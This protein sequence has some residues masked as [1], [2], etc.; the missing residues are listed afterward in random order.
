MILI[1]LSWVYIFLT[2]AVFGLA[3]SKVLRIQQ[4]DV[5][6]TPI[7]GLFSVTIFAT[8]WAFFSPIN[9][10]FHCVLCIVSVVFWYRN[11]LGFQT[12][13]QNALYQFRL[14]SSPIKI[15][16]TFSSLLILTQSATSPFIIDNESYYIQTIKW[17]NEYGFIKGLANLHLFLGQ[18]SG[19]H[20]TQSIYNLSFLYDRFNDINGFCLLLGNVFA[21]KKL[22]SYFTNRNRMDLVFGLVPLSYVFLF[23]FVSSPSPDLPVY[24]FAFILFSHYLQNNDLKDSFSIIG[25]IALFV[26]FIKIT[27]VI[28]LLLPLALAI[29]HFVPLKA[30]LIK[31][32][33][34]GML[35]FILFI[36]KNT[37]LTGYPLFPLL[38]FGMESLDYTVPYVI[39]EFFYS[40]SML[41]SFY[42]P[43]PYYEQWNTFDII[44]AYFF[45]NG[46]SGYIG[47]VSLLV[48]VTTPLLLLREK[49]SQKVWTI[50]LAFAILAILLCF[51]S[52]QYRFYVYFS[53]FFL[54]LFL[55]RWLTNQNWIIGLVTISLVTVVV[56]VFVPMSYST[57]TDNKLLGQNN[58]FHLK[59]IFIP[60]RNSKWKPEYR[61]GSVGNMHYQCPIDTSFFW[62]TGNGKLPC[63]NTLQLDYFRKG[64]FYI[65]Q[66]RSIELGDGFYSQKVSGDE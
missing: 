43:Y 34:I 32:T 56:L 23:Q 26:F 11:K 15:L 58:T 47:I 57:L 48:L 62:V 7:L 13:L 21:F 65:P 1:L 51:S 33:C 16:F 55:S 53:L 61:G 12:T 52:P 25:I 45:N 60:E 44:N 8:F 50:Y 66:Q 38:C 30:S 29:R 20:I 36:A 24:V 9:I 14:F 35:V 37:M 19:W 39:M 42:I 49:L 5:V 41:H 4:L 59:N 40:K 17:I 2:A 64:F 22:H 31:L 28:L 54:L 10:M 27:A 63:I 3:F 18:T 6:I 46:I